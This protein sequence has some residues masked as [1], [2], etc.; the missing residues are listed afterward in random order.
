MCVALQPA[1]AHSTGH[2]IVKTDQRMTTGGELRHFV[3]IE[4]RFGKR[5]AAL[6]PE[7]RS[8]RVSPLAMPPVAKP[9]ELQPGSS[10]AFINS[11][12]SSTVETLAL[13][14]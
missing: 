12:A 1:G 5:P 8:L 9:V 10:A 11:S 7:G 3:R 14:A 4:V 6:E 13:T 2:D